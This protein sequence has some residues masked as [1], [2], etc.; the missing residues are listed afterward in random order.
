MGRLHHLVLNLVASLRQ[1]RG[2]FYSLIG[3]LLDSIFLWTQD[4]LFHTKGKLQILFTVSHLYLNS[5]TSSMTSCMRDA[6]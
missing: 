6:H 5:I 4:I 1:V 2:I 3:I